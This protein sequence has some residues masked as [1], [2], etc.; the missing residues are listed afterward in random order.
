MSVIEP[1]TANVTDLESA[2]QSGSEGSTGN[3]KSGGAVQNPAP[4][5]C[6]VLIFNA[7]SITDIQGG[8][9]VNFVCPVCGATWSLTIM[10]DDYDGSGTYDMN[11][12]INTAVPDHNDLT[13]NDCSFSNTAISLFLAVHLD[14]I[15]FYNCMQESTDENG[16]PA[17]WWQALE[18]QQGGLT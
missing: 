1:T 9:A 13:G 15:G 3:L 16:I 17:N 8:L 6:T 10:F 7:V 18:A 4:A 12:L 5:S 2:A 14:S 11:N